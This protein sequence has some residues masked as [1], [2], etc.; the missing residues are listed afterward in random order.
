MEKLNILLVDNNPGKL[1]T[2]ETM[3]SELGQNL[4]TATSGD[5]ALEHLL[6][7]EVTVILLDVNMPGVDGFQLADLIREH[8][9]HQD[10]AIIF[11]SAAR[12]TDEDR[13]NGYAHGAVDYITVP[14]APQLFRARVAVFLEL[15]RSKRELKTLND[16]MQQLSVRL[17][18]AQDE[19]RR[20]IAR[21][22][23]DS[24]SQQLTLAKITVDGIKAPNARQQA[25]EV[26]DQINEALRQVRTISHLLHPPMLDD[27]GLVAAIHWCLDGLTKR[28]GIDT[29]LTVEPSKFPRLPQRHEIAL[30]RIAQEALTNAV[31]HSGGRQIRV[32]LRKYDDH[33]ALAVADNG[34]GIPENIAALRFG[35]SGLGLGGMR[36]RA[37]EL[38]G[39][40]RMINGT[41]GT[42]VEVV[43]P[44]KDAKPERSVSTVAQ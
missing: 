34:S 30:Y 9:R 17:M 39:E 37:N 43:I 13:L 40:M 20:R 6:K 21:E 8:P 15:H 2:Y 41:P 27:I 44:M 36:Q 35:G 28:G 3:L 18:A 29:S 42:V 24:L 12:L 31:R 19:E 10:T 38:G 25:K 14:I 4:I 22:L 23:H 1:L 26:G 16:Q 32:V 33:V 7:T 5:E 11:V